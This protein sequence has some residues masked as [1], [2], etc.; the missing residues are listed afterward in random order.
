MLIVGEKEAA[1]GMVSVRKHGLGDLG[2]MSIEDFKEQII[3]E[4]KV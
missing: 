3:K 2:S 1:E 4:I